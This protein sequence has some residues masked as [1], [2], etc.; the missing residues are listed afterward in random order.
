MVLSRAFPAAAAQYV[1]LVGIIPGAF[2]V[3]GED[4]VGRL[5]LGEEGG[6]AFCVAM[7]AVWVQLE[8]FPAICLLEPTE[9]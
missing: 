4:F 9:S 8:G 7:V 6:G 1:S 5:D 2:L 3:V